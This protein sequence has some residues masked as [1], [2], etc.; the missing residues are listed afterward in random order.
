MCY[1]NIISL[2]VTKLYFT[3]WQQCPVWTSVN[4][5]SERTRLLFQHEFFFF[6]DFL[7]LPIWFSR[8]HIH[9]STH[10]LFGFPSLTALSVH[11]ASLE[12]KEGFPP[13][14][15]AFGPPST[16][17]ETLNPAMQTLQRATRLS[18]FLWSWAEV[19]IDT[20]LASSPS[21]RIAWGEKIFSLALSQRLNPL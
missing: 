19:C 15:Q 21:S 16:L 7:F 6:Y 2:C 20:P 5:Q 4:M 11:L 18:L 8:P 12:T 14:Q 1:F 13:H 10:T 3:F 17:T 9:P